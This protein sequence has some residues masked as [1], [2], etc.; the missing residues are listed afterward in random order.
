M[1]DYQELPASEV[2]SVLPNVLPPEW[3]RIAK[4]DDG[5]AF[6]RHDGLRVIASMCRES[7]GRRW[8]HVSASRERRLPSWR[9]LR[10]VKNLFL[11]RERLAIQVLPNE[12]DYYNLHP[13]CLHLWCC[14]DGPP[15]VPDFRKDGAL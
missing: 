14:L 6:E 15:V 8:V 2:W 5:G 3:H 13:F 10:D 11:G 7:D 12:S 1:R 4:G 9:D